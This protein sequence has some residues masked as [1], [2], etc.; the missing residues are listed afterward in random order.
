MDKTIEGGM[1]AND[2]CGG[3]GCIRAKG[4]EGGTGAIR[5]VAV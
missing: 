4:E 5:W 1:G 2:D 3:Y